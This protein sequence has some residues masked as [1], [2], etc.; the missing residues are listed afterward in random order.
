MYLMVDNYDSFVHTLTSYFAELGCDMR[1]VRNDAL[2]VGRVLDLARGGEL[3]GVV[4]SPGPKTPEQSGSCPQ[5][6]QALQQWGGASARPVPILG[7]CLG[8][9]VIAQANGAR[10][11]RGVRPMHGKV[12]PIET[13]GAGLFSGLPRR[14]KVTRYHSLVVDAGHLPPC[15]RVDAL[16][17]D[18]AVMAISHRE[19]PV[20]GVQF[21]PEA[22]LTS[23]GH[24]LLGSF[25][26]VCRQASE[27]AWAPD[28]AA[29][30]LPG[31]PESGEAFAQ[32]SGYRP[33]VRAGSWA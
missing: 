14:F 28:P 4:I 3:Q 30:L 13:D 15:L 9:Q 12:T 17:D 7:V 11:R 26:R 10:V 23:Y 24:E 25:L 2:D 33:A 16:A 6:V 29:G 32:L 20:F 18:G 27:G 5:L 8:H 22:V 21:H 19:L 31:Q 1:I